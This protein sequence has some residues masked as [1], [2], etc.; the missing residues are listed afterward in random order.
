MQA[1]GPSGGR[2]ASLGCDGADAQ[3][4]GQ[5]LSVAD[6]ECLAQEIHT[7]R[8]ARASREEHISDGYRRLVRAMA[9]GPLG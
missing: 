1:I 6:V 4:A 9:G 3:F 7:A 2:G 5:G 8:L